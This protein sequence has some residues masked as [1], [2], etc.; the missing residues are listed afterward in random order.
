LHTLSPVPC[1]ARAARTPTVAGGTGET[2][3]RSSS[4]PTPP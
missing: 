3:R 4:P 2:R 1:A